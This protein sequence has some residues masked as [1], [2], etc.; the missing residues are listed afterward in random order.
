MNYPNIPNYEYLLYKIKEFAALKAE[1]GADVQTYLNNLYSKLENEINVIQELKNNTDLE[2]NEPDDYNKIVKLSDGESKKLWKSFDEN[3]YREKLEGAMLSRFAGCTLGAP[4]EG[5]DVYHV[6]NFLKSIGDAYPPADYLSQVENPFGERYFYSR[7]FNFSR[8][9][10]NGV[11]CDDDITYTILGL[12]IAE[13]SG[14]NFTVE[15]VGKSWVKYLPVACTAE[16]VALRNLKA[17]I[18]AEKV[19][20]INNPYVQWIGADIRSDPWGY[21]APAYPQFAA[22]MAYT[23]AYI[24]H[25]RNGI[26]GEMFFSAVISAA[27]AVDNAVDAYKIGLKYIPS[28]CWLKKEIDWALDVAKDIKDYKDARAA[29][30]ERYKG[31]SSVHTLNNA[32]FTIW[33]TIIGGNDITKVLSQTVAMGLDND[34]TT[35]TAG[36][37]AGAIAGKKN[38][39]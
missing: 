27:F 34:C 20:E 12:L 7:L 6:E 24:S 4:I 19:G 26:Y 30:G 9:G 31:M 17:G 39:P 3:I 36:S 15:D 16:D 1:Y 29:V 5:V 11:P 28:E 13:D 35:A 37:I 18:P 10:M 38:V 8:P 14:L 25:R 33:G 2:I 22:K 32:C 23:D 21:L